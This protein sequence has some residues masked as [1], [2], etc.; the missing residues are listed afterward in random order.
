MNLIT[1]L[2]A[3]VGSATICNLLFE[4][5]VKAAQLLGIVLTETELS[6]LKRFF[7]ENKQ[8]KFCGQFSELRNMLCRKPPCP[9]AVVLPG[10]AQGGR[11]A[12]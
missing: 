8:E 1:L 7:S 5:P 2:G 4:D 11:A 6:E 12:A 9:F 10:H 3:A